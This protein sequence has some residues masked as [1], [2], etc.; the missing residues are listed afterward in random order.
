ML[1]C[2]RDRFEI[3]IRIARY[4]QKAVECRL[5]AE[6]ADWPELRE[7]FA[8]L[9]VSYERMASDVVYIRHLQWC[10]DEDRLLA[11]HAGK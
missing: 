6:I 10:A 5:K 9:A 1:A 2:Q 8:E 4:R 7:C 11:G 3:V